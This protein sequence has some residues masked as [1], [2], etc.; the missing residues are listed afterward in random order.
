MEVEQE[1][2]HGLSIAI[3]TFWPSIVLH[4]GHRIVAYNILKVIR[5]TMMDSKVVI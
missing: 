5:D 2:T 4:L 3:A 1:A